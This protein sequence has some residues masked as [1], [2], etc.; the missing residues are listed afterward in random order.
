M[1]PQLPKPHRG[2]LDQLARRYYSPLLSFF[3]RRTPNPADVQDLVQQVFLRL[4][5][6]AETIENPDAYVFRSAANVL[7]DHYRRLELVRRFMVEE[8]TD[9]SGEMRNAAGVSTE[10]VILGVEAMARVVAALRELPERTRDIFVLR[11]FEGMKHV[12]IA[13]LNGISVRAVEKHV[14]KALAHVGATLEPQG[15]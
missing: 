7:R 6:H 13:R 9:S 4:S 14:A 2:T 8:P 5:S 10:R 3:R 15:E 12:D 1:T 11:C